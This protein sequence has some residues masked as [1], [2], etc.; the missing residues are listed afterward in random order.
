MVFDTGDVLFFLPF[1]VYQLLLAESLFLEDQIIVVGIPVYEPLFECFS[2]LAAR[3]AGMGAVR[4]TAPLC[5]GGYV[6]EGSGSLLRS[7]GPHCSDTGGVKQKGSAL[8]S[9]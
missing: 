6:R 7:P 2:H 5:I 9:E 3:F 8:N 1:P 4:E